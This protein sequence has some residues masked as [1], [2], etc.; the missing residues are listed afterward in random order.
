LT[1]ACQD[2]EKQAKYAALRDVPI[3]LDG[4]RIAVMVNAGLRE[5]MPNLQLTGADGVGLS[6]PSFSSWFPPPCPTAS[7]RRGSIAKCWIGG[8][9]AGGVPHRRHRRGQEPALSAP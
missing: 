6:A 8:G 9:Q 4:E 7:A 3:T 5:D 2:R 1:N